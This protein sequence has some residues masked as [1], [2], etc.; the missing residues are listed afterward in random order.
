M[1]DLFTNLLGRP[2][3]ETGGVQ[4]WRDVQES[5]AP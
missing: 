3:I 5:F 1:I 4:L 2:P